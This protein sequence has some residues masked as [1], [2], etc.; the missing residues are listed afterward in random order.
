MKYFQS[1]KGTERIIQ[2]TMVILFAVH[3]FA[4]FFY[5]CAKMYDFGPNTWVYNVGILDDSP[6]DS[7]K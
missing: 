1:S 2:L 3:L 5:L 7:W 6:Y 4:C